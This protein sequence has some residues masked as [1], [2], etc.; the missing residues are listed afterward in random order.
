M[1]V[2]DTGFVAR[3]MT[4]LKESKDPA[5]GLREAVSPCS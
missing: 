4:Q 3:D 5:S 2:V 1:V